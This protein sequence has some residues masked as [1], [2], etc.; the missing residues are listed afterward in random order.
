MNVRRLDVGGIV[1]GLI[2]LGVGIWFMLDKTFGFALPEVEWDQIWPLFI[3]ALG[4]AVLF[5]AWA[6]RET[7]QEPES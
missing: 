1:F 7:K 4:V 6:R 5:G 3:I 2:L